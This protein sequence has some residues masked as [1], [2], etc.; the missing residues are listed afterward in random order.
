MFGP[1]GIVLL[2]GLLIF[3]FVGLAKENR[4]NMK[5]KKVFG[6]VRS[7]LFADFISVGVLSII[8]LILSPFD[9]EL[10]KVVGD[11]AFIYIGLGALVLALGVLIYIITLKKCPEDLKKGLFMNMFLDGWGI[12]LKISLFFLPFVFKIGTPS[13]EEIAAEERRREEE[14]LAAER[15]KEETRK[16]LYRKTG[17]NYILNDDGDKAK[18][19][20]EEYE[21]VNDILKK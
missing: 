5:Y 13:P 12:A 14:R 17:E 20:Y 11:N 18:L 21:N 6:R 9:P 8:V 1:V 10:K 3:A 19:P 15:Q 4:I 7:Y 16:D 2:I